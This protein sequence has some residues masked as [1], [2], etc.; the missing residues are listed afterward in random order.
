MAEKN[1]AKVPQRWTS[2]Q[3]YILA[4]ICLIL[5]FGVGYLLRGPG[6]KA[7]PAAAGAAPHGMPGGG[8]GQ[9]QQ[10][11]PEQLKAMADQQAQPL[12]AK[13]K[14]SPN[15]LEVLTQLGNLYYDAQ[16]YP[17]A[18]DYYQKVLAQ[19]PKDAAVRTDLATAEFYLGNF[20]RSI[21]EF[22]QA[23]KDDPKNGNALFNRG[24]AKWQGKMD[25]DGAVADW[26]R[27]L[28]ENPN[29]EHA[30]QVRKYVEEANKHR[31]IKPGQ[32]TDKPAM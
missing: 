32:K 29:Y 23:L 12:L 26:N 30:D 2:L 14:S 3:A 16:V 27:L 4:V 8:A 17:S 5:G 25:V 13:L 10:P 9:P 6:G 24:I 31:S 28:K 18:I 22:D 20:D 1:G 19:T 15:D 11:S 7:A 21:S